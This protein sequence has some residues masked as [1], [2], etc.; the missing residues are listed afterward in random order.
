MVFTGLGFAFARH[1]D[2]H[3]FVVF[4]G[5]LNE[6]GDGARK[7]RSDCSKR[8]HVVEIDISKDKSVASACAYVKGSL[9]RNGKSR[10]KCEG[11]R[12]IVWLFFKVKCVKVHIESSF[13]GWKYVHWKYKN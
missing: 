11:L 1:L 12:I 4:A 13:V 10:R 8:L 2:E 9:P 5:C 3:G 6:N 7:L